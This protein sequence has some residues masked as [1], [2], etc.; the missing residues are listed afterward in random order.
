[1]PT[2]FTYFKDNKSKWI[3]KILKNWK[4]KMSYFV[5]L[6]RQASERIIN[7]KCINVRKLSMEEEIKFIFSIFKFIERYSYY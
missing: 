4:D 5:Y 7:E 2:N 3:F 6:Y 1:M